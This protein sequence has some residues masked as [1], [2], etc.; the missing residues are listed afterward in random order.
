MG[1]YY[2][3]LVLAPGASWILE[4]STEVLRRHALIA[5][6]IAAYS[7]SAVAV[8]AILG[9]SDQLGLSLYSQPLYMV[10]AAFAATFLIGHAVYV[11]VVLRPDQL[12]RTII[13]DL[14]DNYLTAERLLP[15]VLIIV[16]LSPFTS[17]YT[18][19][20]VMIPLIQPY[21]WDPALAAFDRT[22]HGG[23]EPW[24]LLQPLLGHPWMTSALNFVYHL[25][26]FVL[27]VVVLWQAFSLKEPKLR[28][29]FFIVFLGSWILVGTFAATAFS[30]VGPVYYAR[31]TGASGGFEPLFAYLYEASQSM[32]VWA[33]DVQS[34]L[35]N[36]YE[37]GRAGIGSGISAMP[38]MHVS[39]AFLLALFGWRK[40]PLLGI[41]LSLFAGAILLGSVHLGWHYAIDGYLAII[42]TW[43][44]W[45]VAGKC[46]GS[47]GD[48]LAGSKSLIRT[49]ADNDP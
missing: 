47:E 14:R 28:Q 9:V 17:A 8:S 34:N 24:L 25:W 29:Q 23:V 20:K 45:W 36:A 38:S 19:F 37:S 10:F 4:Q 6:I 41:A 40:G 13:E 30:S 15:G 18:T 3:P 43:G 35:W 49:C 12:T 46:L 33:L 1:H 48:N 2:L 42:L 21:V 22:L 5:F 16:L 26:F 32:P 27:F 7:L 39:M 11:M 44:I 31:V